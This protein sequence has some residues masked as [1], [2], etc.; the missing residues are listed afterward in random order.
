MSTLPVQNSPIPPQV[1]VAQLA[2]VLAVPVQEVL[3]R[4]KARG[5]HV[6]GPKSSV[7][8]QAAAA[9]LSDTRPTGDMLACRY[10]ILEAFDIARASGKVDWEE[11]TL[12]VLKNRLLDV[13]SGGFSEIDYGAPNMAY[14]SY[15]FSDLL[16]VVDWTA[17]PQRV[18]LETG[19]AT[20]VQTSSPPAASAPDQRL[21]SDLWNAFFDYRAHD[22]YVWDMELQKAIA[23]V[24]GEK[25][26]L[27]PSLTP[28]E[29]AKLREKFR[30]TLSEETVD[31]SDVDEWIL[32]RLGTA[33]LP[34]PLRRSW[35]RFLREQ[36]TE[37][38]N[39]FFANNALEIPRDLLAEESVRAHSKSAISPLR[40]LV[41]RCIATMTDEEL[42]NL[43]FSAGVVL[44]ANK[45]D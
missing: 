6:A 2:E 32:K 24:P 3:E 4:L 5:V 14:F 27:I 26:L 19:A 44:R 12:A 17:T 23:G 11:M 16:Q 25:R 34:A 29:E 21:R 41:L 38:V 42:S 13:T 45:R 22:S 9:L 10:L 15:L 28:Q 37:R 40:E 30:A 8:G 39:S 31:L 18:R 7:P 20:N 1:R 33:S 43:S 35:N 36:I